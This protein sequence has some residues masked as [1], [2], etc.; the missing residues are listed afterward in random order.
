MFYFNNHKTASPSFSGNVA[1]VPSLSKSQLPPGVAE[2]NGLA[3]ATHG[4]I[5]LDD[6][7]LVKLKIEWDKL[8]TPS[9]LI[10]LRVSD[11]ARDAMSVAAHAKWQRDATGNASSAYI[12]NVRNYSAL[13]SEAIAEVCNMTTKQAEDILTDKLDAL[14][15]L[16]KRLFIRPAYTSTLIALS[17]LCQGYLIACGNKST[18]SEVENAL[19]K[20]KWTVDGAKYAGLQSK[21][22]DRSY[23]DVFSEKDTPKLVATAKTEWASLDAECDFGSVELLINAIRSSGPVMV[24]A[25]VANAYMELAKKLRMGSG[26]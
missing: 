4:A 20:M 8:Q 22:Q 25:L 18:G 21:V 23:W 1:L 11:G 3:D 19:K 9:I 24:A 7:E 5:H 2:S 6:E 15:E 14:P 17:I 12:L 26:D 13:T 16:L 10:L